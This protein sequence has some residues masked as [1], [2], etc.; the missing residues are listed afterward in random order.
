MTSTTEKVT[1]EFMPDD[2]KESHRAAGNW[3]RWPHNGAVREV[4]YESD[5]LDMVADDADG[6]ARILP[7]RPNGWNTRPADFDASEES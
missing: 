3:G 4:M 1:V 7:H 5:A 2:K 6:Y